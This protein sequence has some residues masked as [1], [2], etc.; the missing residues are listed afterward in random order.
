M[1]LVKIK[2]RYFRGFGNSEWVNLDNQ[3][4]LLYGLNGNGKT[5]I[6]EAVEWLLYGRTTRRDKGETFSQRDYQNTHRNVHAPAEIVTCVEAIFRLDDE[7]EKTLRRDLR[8]GNRGV[9]D[10]VTYIDGSQDSFESIGIVDNGLCCPVIAQHSLQDFIYS[11]PKDRRDKISALLGLEDLV[12]FKTSMDK[13][14]TR[15]QVASVSDNLR[16]AQSGVTRIISA[17]RNSTRLLNVRTRWGNSVFNLV[18]DK[19]EILEVVKA[20]LGSEDI[21][22]FLVAN[23]NLETQREQNVNRIF[24]VS[25]LRPIGNLEAHLQR[26]NLR[27]ADMTAS[28]VKLNNSIATFF[29][30]T[31]SRYSMAQMAFW[32]AGMSLQVEQDKCP[33]CESSTLTEDKRKELQKRI[34]DASEYNTALSNVENDANVVARKVEQIGDEM[35][36]AFPS[37][38]TL[39]QRESL[40]SLFGDDARR[41]LASNP[42]VIFLEMHDRVKTESEQAKLELKALS[43]SIQGLPVKITDANLISTVQNFMLSVQSNA[44]SLLN[45]LEAS[46]R[47]YTNGYQIFEGHLKARIS[48][49]SVVQE[50]DALLAPINGWQDIFVI[51]K[52]NE[53]LNEALEVVRNIESHIRTKQ[54]LLFNARGREISYWYDK[55]NPGANVR[56]CRMEAATDSLTLWAQSFGVDM[57]AVACLSQCQLNCL[58]LSVNLM[59]ATSPNTPFSFIMLDDPVQSMDEDHCETLIIEIMKELIETK[60]LQVIVLSHT[61]GLIDKMRETYYSRLPLSL[62][63]SEFNSNGPVVLSAETLSDILNHA[64]KY[65][66]GNEAN[67]RLAVKIIRRAVESLI[68]EVCLKNNSQSPSD[69][70]TASAMLPFFRSCSATTPVQAEGLQQTIAFCDPSPHTQVGWAPP[71]STQIVPH[72]DRVRQYGKVLGLMN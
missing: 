19:Q 13:A 1:K 52:Y 37:F 36:L 57:S 44:D 54:D 29:A 8:V 47:D 45:R 24:D 58:G 62:M 49:D 15:F 69:T 20:H 28:I 63:I 71:P 55:M 25:P 59:R 11:K 60:Q 53:L 43:V 26:T 50:I 7:T 3:F 40:I 38:L 16:N 65:A 4:V 30:V 68:R 48:D 51:A 35:L 64:K 21:L 41:G 10:S 66:D 18:A 2:P 6:A 72:I 70:A 32:Q 5:S 12:S 46:A 9:E 27:F 14:R 23:R 42:C 31:A 67:R 61:K 34:D 17:M 56:Y 33:M 39:Q 22:D